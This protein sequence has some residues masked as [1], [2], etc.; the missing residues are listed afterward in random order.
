M[1]VFDLAGLQISAGVLVFIVVVLVLTGQLVPR[2]QLEDLREDREMRVAALERQAQIWQGAYESAVLSRRTSDVHVTQLM[3]T[4]R[5]A[6]DMLQAIPSMQ[7]IDTAEAQLHAT[8]E[9]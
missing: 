5:V 4:A 6:K 2:R 9:A 1:S 3:E 8:E 7:Q